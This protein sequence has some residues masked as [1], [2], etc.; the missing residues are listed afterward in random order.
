M[1]LVTMRRHRDDPT[2]FQIRAAYKATD[3]QSFW[4]TCKGWVEF[5]Q[6]YGKPHGWV[7]KGKLYPAAK[8]AEKR[9][10][11]AVTGWLRRAKTDLNNA[12]LKLSC[13]APKVELLKSV[14]AAREALAKLVGAI[15]ERQD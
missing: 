4:V 6:K 11:Y 14:N 1:V 10:R 13:K 7:V 8:V 9:S 12:E 15:E 5:N 3:Q 2:L